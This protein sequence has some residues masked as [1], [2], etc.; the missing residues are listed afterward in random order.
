MNMIEE[1]YR[2]N[3]IDTCNGYASDVVQLFEVDEHTM[4][5]FQPLNR[6]T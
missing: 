2:D 5:E 4:N 3:L 1:P 6:R